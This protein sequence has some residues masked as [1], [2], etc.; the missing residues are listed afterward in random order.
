MPYV[1][2]LAFCHSSPIPLSSQMPYPKRFSNCDIIFLISRS[3]LHSV[4]S[5]LASC[6]GQNPVPA[7]SEGEA[8]HLKWH[9]SVRVRQWMVLTGEREEPTFLGLL[10]NL[11]IM[12]LID[13]VVVVVHMQYM[14]FHVH[15]LIQVL[16][17]P[18]SASSFVKYWLLITEILLSLFPHRKD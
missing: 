6:Q 9:C 1:A 8:M 3:T 16:L 10:F 2:F 17:L 5:F 18:R 11:A 4:S 15:L 13:L 7:W 14:P 12:Q